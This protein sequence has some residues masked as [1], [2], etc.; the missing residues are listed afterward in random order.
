M[1]LKYYS[2]QQTEDRLA[3]F[4]AP[5]KLD[6]S[7]L[8]NFVRSKQLAPYIWFHGFVGTL[9][10]DTETPYYENKVGLIEPI[11]GYLKLDYALYLD[12]L[13]HLLF[14][15]NLDIFITEVAEFTDLVHGGQVA[16]LF[17]DTG[18][19]FS[20]NILLDG[21][22]ELPIQIKTL[23]DLGLQPGVAILKKD[24][25]FSVEE[26]EAL[27]P[28]K[29]QQ[30]KEEAALIEQLQ[31]ENSF[32]KSE[33]EKLTLESKKV[34]PALDPNKEQ[35]APEICIAL[36]LNEYIYEKQQE[37]TS[38]KE[39]TS[40]T[41]LLDA[42]YKAHDLNGE[43]TGNLRDRLTTVANFSKKDPHV[44]NIAKSIA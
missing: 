22:I 19:I 25:Y 15:N 5:V 18:V 3:Q 36:K 2:L 14:G 42:F 12:S 13:Q 29:V 20:K 34:H 21:D 28:Q 38:D 43:K 16:T 17:N 11:R 9:M 24:I 39:K 7:T 33:N 44:L 10:G 37:P 1:V 6:Q 30:H 40:K 35:F 32:L 31:K 4:I 8:L 41:D 23:C 27:D 26:V